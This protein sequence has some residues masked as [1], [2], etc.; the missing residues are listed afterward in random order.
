M[1]PEGRRDRASL[2]ELLIEKTGRFEFLQAVRLFQKIWSDRTPVGL[3]EDPRLETVRFR[4]DVSSAF[5]GS[6]VRDAVAP[7]ED[8]R[9]EL[10]VTFFG[11]ATPGD[12]GALPR[13]YAEEIRYQARNKNPAMGDFFDIFNHR[14]IS[15]FYRA[16]EKNR[17]I[18]AYESGRDNLF[19]RTLYSVLGVGTEGL[20]GRFSFDDQMLLARGGLLSMRP[21][22]ALALESALRSL[23][24]LPVAI[25]Q[26]IPQ[27]CA[28]E[29]EDQ[30]RLGHA[31]SRLGED[32]YAGSEITLLQSKFRVRLGPLTRESYHDFLPDQRAFRSLMEVTRFAVEEGMEFD[33]Q[34]VLR[35]EDVAPLRVGEPQEWSPRLGWTSWLMNEPFDE[36]ADDAR[37]EPESALF[38]ATET[39]EAG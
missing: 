2:K 1:A 16:A 29:V 8:S 35:A 10:T 30:N 3:D 33:L 36:P 26:F 19:E 20:R 22:P 12:F 13:R 7:D 38:A 31:N 4:S 21:I 18:L 25:E 28:I 14:L 27:R 11:V 24:G 23:F 37:F 15:L 32:L 39:V 9:G 34:L 17:L 6:E 5:P